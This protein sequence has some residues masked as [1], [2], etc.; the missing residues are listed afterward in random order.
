MPG[1]TTT[2]YV[3]MALVVPLSKIKLWILTKQKLQQQLRVC[4]PALPDLF[5]FGC[6]LSSCF[7]HSVAIRYYPPTDS[8]SHLGQNFAPFVSV[9][10][11][12]EPFCQS[13]FSSA[14]FPL[15]SD[16][17]FPAALCT[18]FLPTHIVLNDY[19]NDWINIIRPSCDQSKFF[20]NTFQASG[21]SQADN[22]L[23]GDWWF[24]LELSKQ[25]KQNRNG[26]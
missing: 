24:C 20:N 17:L 1:K 11:K 4:S 5:R 9:P 25:W 23:F 19:D 13:V 8:Q 6:G 16:H 10:L 3:R 21:K 12:G 22:W 18:M 2:T 14:Y 26:H 15:N 7:L